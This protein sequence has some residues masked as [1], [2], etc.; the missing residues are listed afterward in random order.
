[1]SQAAHVYVDSIHI[2]LIMPRFPIA[3]PTAVAINGRVNL[4]NLLEIVL[5]LGRK[6][7]HVREICG[8]FVEGVDCVSFLTAVWRGWGVIVW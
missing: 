6:Y 5:Q 7:L 1:M 8:D 4:L 3:S 2:D